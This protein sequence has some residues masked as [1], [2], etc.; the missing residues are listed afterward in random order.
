MLNTLLKL[1]IA[2]RVRVRSQHGYTIERWPK[3]NRYWLISAENC[4]DRINI[5]HDK[6]IKIRKQKKKRCLAIIALAF[7]L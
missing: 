1:K 3:D 2:K 5:A 6:L 4:G 7:L